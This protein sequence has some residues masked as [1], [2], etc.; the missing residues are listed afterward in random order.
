MTNVSHLSLARGREITEILL[1]QQTNVSFISI[2]SLHC[3]SFVSVILLY[4]KTYAN[5][6]T[7]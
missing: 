6:F 1:K 4:P 2:F 3:N 7:Y 5:Q